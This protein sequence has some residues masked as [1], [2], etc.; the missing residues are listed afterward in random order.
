MGVGVRQYWRLGF[1]HTLSGLVLMGRVTRAIRLAVL[2][3]VGACAGSGGGAGTPPGRAAQ[4]VIAPDE[5]ARSQWSNAFDM[6]KNLRPRW[7]V[8]RG[9][10]TIVGQPGEVQVH[11][12]DVR[13]GGPEALRNISV[14]DIDHIQFYDPIT[15]AGRWGLGYGQGMIQVVTRRR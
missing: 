2:M 4:D 8:P 13:V 12:D 6:V 14:L 9:R 3:S 5:M 7:L 11:L 1:T 10:D 15:A